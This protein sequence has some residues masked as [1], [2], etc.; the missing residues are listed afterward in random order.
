MSPLYHEKGEPQGSPCGHAGTDCKKTVNTQPCLVWLLS[1][2]RRCIV[3]LLFTTNQPQIQRERCKLEKWPNVFYNQSVL[4][5]C[6]VSVLIKQSASDETFAPMSLQ[7]L[8]ACVS[9]CGKIFH[10]E[11]CSREFASEVSN[12]L[13][14]VCAHWLVMSSAEAPPV[15]WE[16]FHLFHDP[17]RFCLTLCATPFHG[18]PQGHP[19]V[20]EKLKALMVEWAEDFRNDPQLSLI[21]AMIKN[22]REQGVTFPAVGSQVGWSS[23]GLSRGGLSLQCPSFN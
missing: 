6:R 16:Y 23:L 12:V 4:H 10:L 8:G 20:C 22:L 14:K 15:I 7:L 2:W 13:N 5:I 3:L 17:W 11:V 1:W 21:S 19:K 9:N 18:C